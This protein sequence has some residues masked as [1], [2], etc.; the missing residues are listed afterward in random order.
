MQE[1]PILPMD[2][3]PP[4]AAAGQQFF[5]KVKTPIF[6]MAVGFVACLFVQRKA[7]KNAGKQISI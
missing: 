2:S 5:D 6:W 7:V 3:T 1:N 4:L